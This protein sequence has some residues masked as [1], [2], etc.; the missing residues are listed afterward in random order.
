MRVRTMEAGDFS[1]DLNRGSCA[2]HTLRHELLC[3]VLE[4]HDPE[5]IYTTAVPM[6]PYAKFIIDR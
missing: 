1:T 5:Y 3:A 6:I 2:G 4:F